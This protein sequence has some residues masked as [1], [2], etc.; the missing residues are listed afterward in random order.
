M[1]MDTEKK[2]KNK[3]KTQVLGFQVPT[4]PDRICAVG[5]SHKY[6][7]R[8][9]PV[10]REPKKSFSRIILGEQGIYGNYTHSPGDEKGEEIRTGKRE[11]N[12][13]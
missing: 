10:P 2:K 7:Q 8:L 11:D 12:K 6:Q 4:L 13:G 1:E 3:K 5:T 9:R